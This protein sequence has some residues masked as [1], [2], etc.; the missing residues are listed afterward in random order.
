MGISNNIWRCAK[1]F[2]AWKTST[3][4]IFYTPI[5]SWMWDVKTS[6]E[7]AKKMS[8]KP[9]WFWKD[10]QAILRRFENAGSMFTKI[11]VRPTW[12]T[13]VLPLVLMT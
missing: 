3:C 5:T 2:R 4:M 12:W 1:A 13:K 10:Y 11:Q 7:E 6:Y 9:Y 8:W